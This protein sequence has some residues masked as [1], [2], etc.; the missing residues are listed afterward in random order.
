[1]KY[2]AMFP[3]GLFPSSTSRVVGCAAMRSYH[4]CKLTAPAARMTSSLHNTIW[5]MMP[6]RKSSPEVTPVSRKED[7]GVKVGGRLR[8]EGKEGNKQNVRRQGRG[9][10]RNEISTTG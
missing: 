3:I 2:C 9:T 1:M 8:V 6:N 5:W 10:K 7:Q 4:L